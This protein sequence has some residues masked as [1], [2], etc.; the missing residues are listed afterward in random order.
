MGPLRRELLD[1]ILRDDRYDLPASYI[2][3]LR[4]EA[5][6]ELFA[7]RRE[8]IPV[9]RRRADDT[10]VKEIKDFQDIVPLLFSHTVY[11][12]YPQNLVEQGKWDALARWLKTLSVDDPTKVD[13][14]GVANVDDWIQRLRDNGHLILATSGSSGKCSFLNSTRG[15][16]ELKTRHFAHM[17]GW[18]W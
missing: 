12:S 14:T 15:D 1:M 5:A 9:L 10:G 4:L 7:E 8:Q 6:R 17:L 11:K 2:E 13:F 18:P 3:P 16:L